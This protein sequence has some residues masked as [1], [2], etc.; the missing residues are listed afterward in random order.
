MDQPVSGRAGHQ[1]PALAIAFRI[2]FTANYTCALNAQ[3][4]EEIMCQLFV[5]ANK[6]LWENHT[7][8]VR[9]DGYST[10]VRLEEFYWQVLTEVGARDGL[11]LGQLITRLYLETVEA[12]HD[13]ENFA[14]FLRVCCG[15]YL[16]LQL[17]GDIPTD[18]TKDIASLDATSILARETAKSKE[19][20]PNIDLAS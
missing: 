8:S 4:W 15:R 10:S 7:R 11:S 5:G 12:G 18:Q 16:A 3:V 2:H 19:H 9:I 13:P 17:S 1:N 20:F 14:S 6:R